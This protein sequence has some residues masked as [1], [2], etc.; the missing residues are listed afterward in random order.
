MQK[1]TPIGEALWPAVFRPAPP[2]QEGKE[3]QYQLSIMWP[4]GR[5]SDK[6]LASLRQAIIDVA[7]EKF[8]KKAEQMLEK[9]QLRSPLRDG[10]D[11]TQ[12]YLAGM[13]YMTARSTD[14]PDVVDENVEDII[15]PKDFYGGCE[16]R[17]DVYL[18]A[19]DRAGNRGVSAILNNVQKT[20][21]GERKGGRRDAASAFGVVKKKNDDQDD[22]M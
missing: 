20:G 19:Y 5:K 6:E 4:K 11:T 12:E 17:M 9:G 2:M 10:D 13:W 15:D 7:T 21:E 3:P 14:R 22:L 8:G 18:F 1:L 16:A